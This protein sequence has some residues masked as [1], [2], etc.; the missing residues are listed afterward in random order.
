MPI[1]NA[2]VSKL[3]LERGKIAI[4][5]D[6]LD[7]YCSLVTGNLYKVVK[8]YYSNSEV[9]PIYSFKDLAMQMKEKYFIKVYVFRGDL[10]GIKIGCDKVSWE[11]FANLLN[12]HKAETIFGSAA[13]VIASG[14]GDILKTYLEPYEG[15]YVEPSPILDIRLS[16]FFHLWTIAD[17]LENDTAYRTKEMLEAGECIRKCA[18]YYF[19]KDFND[20]LSRIIQPV[21]VF[22]ELPP[23]NFF[24][25]SLNKNVT[26]I[27]TYPTSSTPVN[28]KPLFLLGSSK[29][30]IAEGTSSTGG[31]G[32]DP[33]D[34]F[35][36][37]NIG[38]LYE[39]FTKLPSQ[40]SVDGAAGKI[41]DKVIALLIEKLHDEGFSEPTL[42]V[43]KDFLQELKD[44]LLN[45]VEGLAKTLY[46]YFEA[47]L[48]WL[49][50]RLKQELTQP[51]TELTP[52][53]RLMLL[54]QLIQS[55]EAARSFLA[56]IFNR[57]LN[58]CYEF[59]SGLFNTLNSWMAEYPPLRYEIHNFWIGYSD[60]I[61]INFDYLKL[62]FLPNITINS[63]PFIQLMNDTIYG[64]ISWENASTQNLLSIVDVVPVLS[65]SFKVK[66][67][68]ISKVWWLM[69]IFEQIFAVHVEEIFG[70]GHFTIE[71]V[72]IMGGNITYGNVRD[73]YFKFSVILTRG[74]SVFDFFSFGCA[75]EILAKAAEYV[76]LGH[77]RL[78][79][80]LRLGVEITLDA[81]EAGECELSQ[82]FFEVA[83]GMMADLKVLIVG[84]KGGMD[85]GA[86]F[87]LRSLDKSLEIFFVVNLW[88]E[89]YIDLWLFD[90]DVGRWDD[91][92][93]WHIYGGQEKA[94]YA[95]F[96]L[97]D[98]DGD[99]LSDVFEAT[100]GLSSSLVDS[101]GDGLSDKFEIDVSGTD[102]TN[103]DTDGDGLSD[104]AEVKSGS[105]R[106]LTNPFLKDTDWDGLSDYEEVMI[107][108]TNP[109]LYDT[110]RDGL[111]D[112]YE[113]TMTYNFTGTRVTPTVTSVKIGGTTY[114]NHTDPLNPDTDGDGLLDGQEG[115]RRGAYYGDKALNGS[116]PS[117]FNFGYTHP[118]DYD[119][120]DDSYEQL[121]DGTM[122]E[123]KLFYLDWNDGI[124][125][126]GK[127]FNFVNVTTGE[128][129]SKVVHTNPC[130]PDTDN[131]T[132]S[133]AIFIN[134]DGR[135]LSLTPPTDPTN[136]DTDSDGLKDGEEGTSD[137]FTYHTDPN[138]PDT[139]ND[140][141]S[142]GE[143]VNK[144]LNPLNPDC[145]GDQVCDGDEVFRYFTNPSINDT[146]GDLLLDGEE[147]FQ[148]YSDPFVSDS[149]NDTIIDGYEAHVYGTDPVNPDTDG[150]GL[151]DNAE[152]GI[153]KTDP[154]NPDTDGDGITDWDELNVYHTN[155]LSWDTDGDSITALNEAGEMTLSCG[156]YD[157]IFM[158]H[159]D[160][161]LS[162]TD[163]DGLSDAQELYLALGSPSFQPIPVDPLNNDT[164]NDGL[165]DGVELQISTINTFLYPYS[166][167]IIQYPYGCSPVINDTDGDGLLDGFEVLTCHSNP[168]APDT[169]SDTLN[170][171]EEVRIYKT[172]PAN[173]DTDGDD[174]ADNVE[175]LGLPPLPEG[176]HTNAT[177]S[178]TD[179]DKLPDAAELL[180]GTD[181]L[182]PD[183]DGDGTPDGAEFDYDN[184]DLNDGDEFYTY[185]T[186]HAVTVTPTAHSG[187]N[188]T[189]LTGYPA[190]LIIGG[191]DNPDSDLDDLTDGQ[192]V[193]TYHTDPTLS[194]TD[195]D[196]FSD[197]EEVRWGTDPLTWTSP[198]EFTLKS[199]LPLYFAGGLAVG[200]GVMAAVALF[201][202]RRKKKSS[203]TKL[204]VEPKPETTPPPP[205]PSQP[206]TKPDVGGT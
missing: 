41:L 164:D 158:Y 93:D 73:F 26:V 125:V 133:S 118:L 14:D 186:N 115:F 25:E 178:D 161:T 187:I 200:V 18:L 177:N 168:N 110:D 195:G 51:I 185:T 22:G 96:G 129:Y 102:P 112:Y 75:G 127:L 27:Q 97:R 203:K 156:D 1:V 90:F 88:F 180:H 64:R 117:L 34:S 33:P 17:I 78:E 101:D 196:G 130:N 171:Y 111:S 121:A 81:A 146:D 76:G 44:Y 50:E 35:I 100:N 3:E 60:W 154:L 172:S 5:S 120:D 46:E 10:N 40:T 45:F 82:L 11:N 197:G 92:W 95:T 189:S 116:D 89:V 138:N 184:D 8:K 19:S 24:E 163:K 165:L 108:R 192:E 68:G 144:G 147:L 190:F 79:P 143:E 74:F 99:G 181:P 85:V 166:A 123:R 169:D 87:L 55:D 149:D 65:G 157:E 148:F 105:I 204:A 188:I 94:E 47:H 155:P 132:A 77:F 109:R 137:Q 2:Q 124:E 182:N 139:D 6:A 29:Q 12:S 57:M 153:H 206:Q 54:L 106:Y 7:P 151:F 39:Y 198:D 71:I 170:D 134:S 91:S 56:E 175:I 103:P 58:V 145:D 113:I 67:F 107:Y 23:S 31:G 32:S 15:F 36:N 167:Q 152:I 13:H 114:Y 49:I 174:L 128:T 59:L 52:R 53:Q 21:D 66:G 202:T 30:G 141:L 193:H 201:V 194:D 126:K 136:G 135:E 176:V 179:G 9:I 140:K 37:P 205:P 28:K 131:D 61:S 150:D 48:P 16:Y 84:I 83:V 38:D 20:L 162:D 98:A 104:G 199:K 62:E 70:E 142:D 173:N 69:R 42:G 122:S 72:K 119:T 80:Y 160:P 4:F 183:T 191:F 63:E 159:T 86:K 43:A